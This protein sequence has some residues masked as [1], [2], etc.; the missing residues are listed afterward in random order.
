LPNPDTLSADHS[1]RYKQAAAISAPNGG[2]IYDFFQPSI[3]TLRLAA[4]PKIMP[5]KKEYSGS[6]GP[7]SHLLAEVLQ[8]L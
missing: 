7:L 2:C 5:G 8:I 3:Q 1:N 6:I 4:A